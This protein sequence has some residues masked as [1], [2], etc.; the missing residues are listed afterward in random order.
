MSVESAQAFAEAIR[1]ACSGLWGPVVFSSWPAPLR[2]LRS[3]IRSFMFS[4][5]DHKFIKSSV[6]EGE[7]T[8][9]LDMYLGMAQTYLQDTMINNR[10]AMLKHLPSDRQRKRYEVGSVRKAVELLCAFTSESPIR[11]LSELS[12]QLQ[13]PKSTTHNLLR[14]LQQ[15]EFVSQDERSKR[16]R[17]GS[18]MF[19]LGMLFQHNM[20][21]EAKALPHL[22]RLAAQTGETVKLALLSGGRALVVA[23]VESS[24]QLHTR[25]DIGLSWPLHSTSLGKAILACLS[26]EEVASI[27]DWQGLPRL[28]D[29]TITTLEDLERSLEKISREGYALDCQEN[30]KGVN[31]VAVPLP[32]THLAGGIVASLSVSGPSSRLTPGEFDELVTLLADKAKMISASLA[33]P[34]RPYEGQKRARRPRA[35]SSTV[36][37]TPSSRRLRR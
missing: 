29:R 20:E 3:S 11:S 8:F 16:Y 27:V 7:Y 35:V 32:S 14:T 17:L 21:L 23:A 10:S 34:W 28:T 5:A 1:Q 13:L 18:K 25:G 19:E 30:E 24:Q 15:F 31:C 33:R 22:R 4:D 26:P 36:S 12:R 37:T 6:S 9:F 2:E